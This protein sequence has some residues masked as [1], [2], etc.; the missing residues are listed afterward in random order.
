M[1]SGVA[2]MGMLGS[3]ET[4]GWGVEVVGVVET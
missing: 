2:M 4:E 1:A 3:K